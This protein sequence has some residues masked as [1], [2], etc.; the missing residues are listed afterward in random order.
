MKITF[1]EE[2]SCFLVDFEEAVRED[3]LRG[4]SVPIQAIASWSELLGYDDLADCLEVILDAR[5]NAREP[6]SD[7]ETGF[8]DVW[9]APYAMLEEREK[10]REEEYLKAQR[11]GQSVDPRSPLLRS[12]LAAFHALP[13][14]ERGVCALDRARESARAALGAPSPQKTPSVVRRTTLLKVNQQKM[15]A[16]IVA[17]TCDE[18]P[19][20]ECDDGQIYLCKEDRQKCLPLLRERALEIGYRQSKFLHHQTELVEDPLDPHL[21]VEMEEEEPKEE[22]SP[23]EIARRKYMQEV[24]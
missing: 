6:E 2:S 24:N 11:E 3:G 22:L 19:H 9:T 16:K 4:V 10:A 13:R 8:N 12:A 5:V 7:P 18:S 1:D 20:V 14:D 15:E 23:N 21:A 17:P